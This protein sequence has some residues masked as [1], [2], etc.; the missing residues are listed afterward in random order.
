[1]A[2]VACVS[3]PLSANASAPAGFLSDSERVSSS[4]RASTS[5]SAASGSSASILALPS[6]VKY[7][8]QPSK[9]NVSLRA[10]PA[11]VYVA[12]SVLRPSL[13]KSA[14]ILLQALSRSAT[15]SCPQSA[16]QAAA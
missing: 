12:Q 13:S 16:D 14:A 4:F 5:R 2:G 3:A 11:F 8:T 6:V 10:E 15:S 1:M 7:F 9:S